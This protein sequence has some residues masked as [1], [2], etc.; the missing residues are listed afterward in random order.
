[1]YDFSR[2]YA[3]VEG[4]LTV[5]SWLRALK[6]GRSVATNGPLLRLSVDGKPTGDVLKL[7]K[8][9]TVRVE[10]E[11]VGRHPFERLQL[12]HNGKV[13]QEVKPTKKGGGL[14]ARLVRAVRIT[15]PGWFAVRIEGKARNE[16]DQVL[17]AH[18]SPC[19][20]DF[21]GGRRFDLESARALLKRLEEARA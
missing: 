7:D 19:Y 10:A 14:S 2:V 3:R 13:V 5:K 6:G 11:G 16:F 15:E 17:F 8:E 12:V 20:V 9:K 18:T 21:E 4:E 1:L